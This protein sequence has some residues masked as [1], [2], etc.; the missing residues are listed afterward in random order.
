M[1]SSPDK[2]ITWYNLADYKKSL[3]RNSGAASRREPEGAR[4]I[5][6][7]FLLELCKTTPFC[8]ETWKYVYF[9]AKILECKYALRTFLADCCAAIQS[10][11]FYLSATE[12]Q[13]VL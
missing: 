9:Y 11:I 4:E 1:P 6:A 10:H 12:Y 8:R 7:T 2:K 5:F 13:I 3:Q